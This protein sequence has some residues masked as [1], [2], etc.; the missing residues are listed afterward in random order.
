MDIALIFYYLINVFAVTNLF[1]SVC[2]QLPLCQTIANVFYFV[3]EF[4]NILLRF[5]IDSLVVCFLARL[6]EMWKVG[7]RQSTLKCWAINCEKFTRWDGDSG[8]E[9]M[10]NYNAE[11][12]VI[13]YPVHQISWVSE[14]VMEYAIFLHGLAQQWRLRKKQNLVQRYPRGWGWPLNFE[15]MHS[16]EKVHDT[17]LDDDK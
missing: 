11:V 5:C 17:T 15:Y 14:W 8:E 4:V 12:Q 1:I 9:V 7:W 3:D 6:W 16:A 2:A 13:Q 10:V